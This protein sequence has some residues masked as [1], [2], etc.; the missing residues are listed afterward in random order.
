[1][2]RDVEV[3]QANEEDNREQRLTLRCRLVS[4]SCIAAGARYCCRRKAPR[5]RQRTNRRGSEQ[6]SRSL[7]QPTIKIRGQMWS[8]R[9]ITHLMA[10][11]HRIGVNDSD[12][13]MVYIRYRTSK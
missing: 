10:R 5:N 8:K 9:S 3:A 12:S 13:D 2:R 4:R 1:M 7:Q 6:R 11:Q